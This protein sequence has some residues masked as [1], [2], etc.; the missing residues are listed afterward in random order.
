MATDCDRFALRLDKG[1]ARVA[2]A[3]RTGE[4]VVGVAS[5]YIQ[6]RENQANRELEFSFRDLFRDADRVLTRG[7]PLLFPDS[8]D[9]DVERLR[10]RAVTEPARR[11]LHAFD[12]VRNGAF[13]NL[14][15]AYGYRQAR[16]MGANIEVYDEWKTVR[17]PF[18][19]VESAIAKELTRRN[20][21]SYLDQDEVTIPAPRRREQG[22]ITEDRIPAF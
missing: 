13:S 19:A 9:P 4:N 18:S 12:D 11:L 6:R 3:L 5:D 10:L 8:P 17:G 14:A 1:F 16:W 7:A 21:R 22:D 20:R 15:E 2:Y